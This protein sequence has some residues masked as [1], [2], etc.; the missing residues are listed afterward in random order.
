MNNIYILGNVPSYQAV[1]YGLGQYGSG[2]YGTGSGASTSI[3]GQKISTTNWSLAN[4]G[5]VLIANP[6][7]FAPVGY[8][9]TPTPYTY[10]QP[11]FIWDPTSYQTYATVLPAAPP[12]STGVI[13]AMPQRQI[14]AW[15]TSF[16]G[17]VDPLLVRWCDVNNYNVWVG[18]I[19]NQAGSYRLP[20][21]STIVDLKQVSQQIFIWTDIGLWAMQYISTPY[22]YSFTQ[23]GFGCGL[24]SRRAAGTLN[25]VTY[26]MG[27]KGFFMYS[28]EGVTAVV[29]PVWDYIFQ[30][31]DQTKSDNI[32]CAPNS[33]F[34]EITWYFPV[35]GGGG[36][37]TMYAK[38]SVLANVWDIGTLSRSAWMDTTILGPPIAYDTANS[39]IVQHETSQFN[40][41]TGTPQTI[42]ASFTTG[43]AAIGD[44]D[45]KIFV[46]QLWPDFKYSYYGGT[47]DTEVRITFTVADY[48]AQGAT[49]TF[50]PYILSYNGPPTYG[51][52]NYL[53]PRF[54]G[55][56]V[57]YTIDTA[58]TQQGWW[59]MGAIRYR[60]QLDGKI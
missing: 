19:T 44:G 53:T 42:P 7:G 37:N 11:I 21:G 28:G 51:V 8:A 35:I 10:Y 36:V 49:Q 25:G 31:F 55:R 58:G 52:L 60:Y 56:L 41:S 59:R 34:Q 17:I 54:R 47:L 39:V 18:Q 16:T 4:W 14:I 29:C 40:N 33:M 12:V 43:Y 50:G 1:G 46:D 27:P 5:Q 57:S 23:I 9:G 2:S 3:V 22:I 32:I 15:G 30:Q 20:S 38:Y 24:I 45:S 6:V 48:P 26:W 13:V